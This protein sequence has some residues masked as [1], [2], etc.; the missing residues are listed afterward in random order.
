MLRLLDE[1]E[2]A[3]AGMVADLYSSEEITDATKTDVR[4]DM[5]SGHGAMCVLRDQNKQRARRGQHGSKGGA[6]LQAL[7]RQR[8]SGRNTQCTLLRRDW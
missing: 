3:M 8:A 1:G 7:G 2:Q 6:H 4:T 5:N